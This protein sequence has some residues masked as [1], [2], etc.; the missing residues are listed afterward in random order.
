[1]QMR[2][3]GFVGALALA[4]VALGFQFQTPASLGPELQ[5]RFGLDYAA[6]G[7][8]I[9]LYMP[10][11]GILQFLLGG[12]LAAAGLALVYV[13]A[14][15]YIPFIYI[16]LIICAFFGIGLGLVLAALTRAGKLRSP[17]GVGALAVVVGLAAVYLE[18]GAYLML[19]ANSETTGSGASAD[20]TTAFDAGLLG[21]VLTDPA[22]MARLMRELNATGTWS[23]KGSTPSGIWLAL[24]WLAEALII[25]GGAYWLAQSQAT[26]PYSETADEW[27]AEE[28]L[29]QSAAFVADP[30]ALRPALE[31]G[32]LQALT[33]YLPQAGADQY[34]RLRL[35]K[36]PNDGNCQYLTLQNVT[37][38]L[39]KKGKATEAV[40]DVVKHLALSPAG[41]AE[42]KRRFG[43]IQESAGTGFTA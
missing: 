19:V 30:A 7:G 17:R 15:W 40:S 3:W 24:I 34:A 43:S 8:L 36:A 11:A 13:Y 4:R 2:Q 38:T 10:P 5:A 12:T 14:V 35:H 23:L 22:G 6:L 31:T 37:R 26:E 25:V 16:N 32:Q 20:T 27:A 41:Y 39:D 9:G 28:K 1:M 18:W 21:R 42:L 33:P 29:T